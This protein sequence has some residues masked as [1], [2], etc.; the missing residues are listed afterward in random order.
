MTLK[1]VFSDRTHLIIINYNYRQIVGNLP[2]NLIGIYFEKRRNIL[3]NRA[4]SSKL[5]V[6]FY[7]I[8]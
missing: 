2:V 1:R 5:S 3:F 4:F 6:S 7:H 8:L